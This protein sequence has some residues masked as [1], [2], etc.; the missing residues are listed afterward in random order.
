MPSKVTTTVGIFVLIGALLFGAGIFMIGDRR[1]LFAKN[2]EL[3]T[4]FA[5]LGGLQK[6]AKVRVSGMDAGEVLEIRVPPEPSAKFRVRFRVVE[7][8]HP[9]LRQDSVATI[10]TDGLLGNKFMQVGA[11]TNQAPAVPADSTI[12]SREPFDFSSVLVQ[13][14]DTVANINQTFDLVK[15]DI[16][17]TAQTLSEMTKHVDEIIVGMN[18][19]IAKVTSTAKLI[20]AN[21]NHVLDGIRAG[22]GTVGKL[23]TD[24]SIYKDIAGTTTSL[25][26]TVKNL[27]SATEDVKK[28]VSEVNSGR[29][30]ETAQQTLTN[31]RDATERLKEALSAVQSTGG[32]GA[33]VTGDLRS[34]IGNAREAMADLAENMEALKRSFFFRGFFKDR[35]FYDLDNITVAEYQ[36]EKFAGKR[37][38]NTEWFS[39][40]QLF[41][42][43]QDGSEQLTEEGQK[44]V[45]IAIANYLP[46]AG[47][48]PVVIEGYCQKG[49]ADEQFLCSRERALKVRNYLLNKF[50]LRSEYVGIVAMGARHLG[51][52]ADKVDGVAVT[53]FRSES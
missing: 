2:V 3:Y 6:G 13:A 34:T 20:A 25:N 40:E 39:F 38:R 12:P 37:K 21:T 31:V 7:N 4:E 26:E 49:M 28:M 46:I 52:N 30:V 27:Q 51:R 16:T 5:D 41:T 32:T 42:V 23:F 11:G 45:G 29:F 44:H 53:F 17:T 43:T 35:G 24:D 48:G 36:S 9:I 10:Q 22:R 15:T 14:R 19:D 50:Q 18:D 47:T 8:L 1:L 33:S